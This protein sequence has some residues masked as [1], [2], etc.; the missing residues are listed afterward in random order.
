MVFY[1]L[2]VLIVSAACIYAQK[3]HYEFINSQ[4][5][6]VD[7]AKLSALLELKITE[8]D[9]LKSKMSHLLLKNGLLK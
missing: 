7:N 8:M 2:S 1:A 6:H 4:R 5:N 9:E 3:K